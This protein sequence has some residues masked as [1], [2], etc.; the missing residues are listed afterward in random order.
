MPPGDRYRI[1][2]GLGL[3]VAAL[4]LVRGAVCASNAGRGGSDA[5]I[6]AAGQSDEASASAEASE[7]AEPSESP[8]ASASPEID[9]FPGGEV[10]DASASP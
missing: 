9:G 10:E 6:N 7:S 3:A 2:R 4:L 5:T 8:E 1:F